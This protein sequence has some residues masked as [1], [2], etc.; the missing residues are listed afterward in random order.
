M[1][2]SKIFLLFFSFLLFLNL[3]FSQVFLELQIEI[4]EDGNVSLITHYFYEDEKIEEK[5][6][7]EGN[8]SILILNEDNEIIKTAYVTYNENEFYKEFFDLKIGKRI[9]KTDSIL[10]N[11]IIQLPNNSKKLEVYLNNI[12]MK[13]Y[14]INVKDKK[15]ISTMKNDIYNISKEKI[16]K[17]NKI[18]FKFL[19][20]ISFFLIIILIVIFLILFKRRRAP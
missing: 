16:E 2:K 5:F 13:E 20:P 12:K 18:D 14:E 3:V 9:E 1:R 17:F 19:I 4:K 6:D 11:V 8:I 7:K 15:M 10:K